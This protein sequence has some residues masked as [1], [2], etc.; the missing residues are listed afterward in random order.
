[1][2]IKL[3]VFFSM[4]LLTLAVQAGEQGHY[5]PGSWSPR[6]LISAPAGLTVFAPYVSSYSASKA[7]TGSGARVNA[8]AGINVGADSWMF[9]PVLVYAPSIKPLGAD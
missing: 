7:R 8:G 4:I 6:D 5:V 3:A 9:T 1:M 2:K